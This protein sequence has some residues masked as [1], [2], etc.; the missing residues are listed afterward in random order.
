MTDFT[1][2]ELKLVFDD[3]LAAARDEIKMMVDPSDLERF[4]YFK[5]DTNHSPEWNTYQFNEMLNIY[6]RKCREWEETHN[7]TMCVVERVRDRYLMPKIKSFV[8]L[9]RETSAGLPRIPTSRE[10]AESMLLISEKYLRDNGYIS[11]EM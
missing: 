6:K 4:W 1:E 9:V 3:M 7:G 2:N 11:T 8:E 5:Y 10:E